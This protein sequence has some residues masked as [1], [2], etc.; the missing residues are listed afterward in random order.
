[1]KKYYYGY[2]T[3]ETAGCSSWYS[4]GCRPR[5]LSGKANLVP[6][7]FIVLDAV[8]HYATLLLFS[9]LFFLTP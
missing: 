3:Q 9:H 5:N 8:K 7:S 6:N 4:P 1:M 2:V